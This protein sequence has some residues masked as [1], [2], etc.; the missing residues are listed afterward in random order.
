MPEQLVPLKLPPGLVNNG[1]VYQTKGRWHL[2]NLVRF[3][4]GN[5]QPI[6]GWVTRAT[7]GAAITGV[8][9]ACIAWQTND[10]ISW[11]AVGTTTGLFV[12]SGA[13]VVTNITPAS[14]TAGGIDAKRVWQLDTF[15]SWLVAISGTSDPTTET[16]LAGNGFMWVWKGDVAA[17]AVRADPTYTPTTG[18]SADP[19]MGNGVVVTAERFLCM[20]R[21]T[22]PPTLG[23]G[24][25]VFVG[26]PL[27]PLP[28]SNISF[29]G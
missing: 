23:V 8:P 24:D 20:L 18:V 27:A 10:G 6:G 22:D 14:I 29:V 17:G 4:Q 21:G 16:T 9:C 13:N 1:T 5:I 25:I 19:S 11:M 7:T 28:P 12:V 3:F 26:D 15:G 2:G